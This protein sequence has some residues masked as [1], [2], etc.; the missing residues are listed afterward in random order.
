ME[1]NFIIDNQLV[2][3]KE[4]KVDVTLATNVRGKC[5]KRY[6]LSQTYSTNY[7]DQTLVNFIYFNIC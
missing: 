4:L 5:S 2:E 7:Y 6:I 1:L 3:L